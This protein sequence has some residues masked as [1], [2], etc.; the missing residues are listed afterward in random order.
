MTTST[1]TQPLRQFDSYQSLEEASERTFREIKDLMEDGHSQVLTRA[2]LHYIIMIASFDLHNLDR[3]AKDLPA[4]AYTF[5]CD[6]E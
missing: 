6:Y 5:S 2:Q 3:H 1:S 4:S